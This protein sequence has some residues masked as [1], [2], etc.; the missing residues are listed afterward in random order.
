MERLGELKSEIA[1][2]YDREPLDL[3][4]KDVQLVNVYSGEIVATN[5]GIKNGRVVTI[6]SSL[7]RHTPTV[8]MDGEQ[9]CH[10]RV[11]RCACAH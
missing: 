4:V 1:A 11:D 10:S 5:I 2:A 7:P 6:S 8:V 9:L 3:F